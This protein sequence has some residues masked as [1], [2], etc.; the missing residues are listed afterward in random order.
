[1]F[2]KV[3]AFNINRAIFWD[4]LYNTSDVPWRRVAGSDWRAKGYGRHNTPTRYFRLIL[5]LA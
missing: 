4:T 5:Y 1:M 2:D 3:K